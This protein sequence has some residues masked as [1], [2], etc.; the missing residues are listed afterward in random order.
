MDKTDK[1]LF[2]IKKNEMD[3]ESLKKSELVKFLNEKLF[4]GKGRV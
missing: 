1:K 3:V 2:V 4:N